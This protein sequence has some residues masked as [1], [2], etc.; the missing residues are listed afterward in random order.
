MSR[1]AKCKKRHCPSFLG[2]DGNLYVTHF[3]GRLLRS[4]AAEPFLSG[5]TQASMVTT[6]VRSNRRSSQVDTFASHCVMDAAL[7]SVFGFVLRCAVMSF[8][9][10]SHFLPARTS[11]DSGWFAHRPAAPAATSI[12]S[13]LFMHS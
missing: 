1:R 2:G 7:L 10:S 5:C 4:L 13:F 12:N 9:R 11:P 8:G 3:W 6:A